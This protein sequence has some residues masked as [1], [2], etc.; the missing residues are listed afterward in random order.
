MLRHK[1]RSIIISYISLRRLIGIL[2]MLLPFICIA[3][4][5][6]FASLPVQP[7]ISLYYYTNMRDF[8]I[9]LLIGVSL[10][11]ITYEGY[12]IIDNIITSAIGLAGL[13]ISFFPC[14]PTGGS[15][16]PAGIF[17]VNAVTANTVHVVCAAVFFSLLAVNSIFLFTLGK[18]KRAVPNKNKRIRNLIYRT[19][20]IVILGSI[21][22]VVIFFLV[23]RTEVI[24][25]YRLVLIFETIMFMAFGVS[26]LVK[27]E[28]LFRDKPRSL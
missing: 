2:G 16:H 9:G 6:V 14:L 17:Q 12:E 13:G 7:S 18:G 27:G 25:R 15:S 11:F 1:N 22:I 4:G 24:D 8:Y 23:M 3:G 19:C 20:G 28:T 5:T 26:W 10:F 21:V